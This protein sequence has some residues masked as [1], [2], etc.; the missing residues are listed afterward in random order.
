MLA[1]GYLIKKDIQLGHDLDKIFSISYIRRRY[2]KRCIQNV[3]TFV[4]EQVNYSVSFVSENSKRYK[5]LLF[6]TGLWFIIITLFSD[7][8]YI[9]KIQISQT[10]NF[11]PAI[12]RVMNL[13]RGGD[14]EH[15]W[16]PGAKY[17]SKSKSRG[18]QHRQLFGLQSHSSS[19]STTRKSSF[20][21]KTWSHADN[22]VEGNRPSGKGKITIKIHDQ[23]E[24]TLTSTTFEPVVDTKNSVA[25]SNSNLKKESEELKFEPLGDK[26][27]IKGTLK[28]SSSLTDKGRIVVDQTQTRRS[29][30]YVQV[31]HNRK[32]F[33]EKGFNPGWSANQ[34]VLKRKHTLDLFGAYNYTTEIYNQLNEAEKLQLDWKVLKELLRHNDSQLF[35]DVMAQARE[36]VF[37]VWNPGNG[38]Y[39]IPNHIATFENQ[40]TLTESHSY[41]TNYEAK[42]NQI[43]RLLESMNTSIIFEDI[44]GNTQTNVGPIFGKAESAPSAQ[45]L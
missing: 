34:L 31:K 17:H 45:E 3:P 35:S 14:V 19:L 42:P 25:E 26:L 6:I 9:D 24:E 12:E 37:L 41:I 18:N 44:H 38:S 40:P 16:S 33:I 36:R 15:L 43:E 32:D 30:P 10:R 2:S 28:D 5:L 29:T 1:E 22:P 20:N 13:Q 21:H 7:F 4:N 39:P 23:K 27:T 11:Q 8:Q